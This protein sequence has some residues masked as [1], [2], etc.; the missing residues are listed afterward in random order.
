M[1]SLKIRVFFIPFIVGVYFLSGE[2]IYWTL[3]PVIF[4]TAFSIY[5][6][7]YKA[8]NSQRGEEIQTV[9]ELIITL[10]GVIGIIAYFSATAAIFWM[11]ILVAAYIFDYVRQNTNKPG[12]Y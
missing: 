9:G 3:V 4:I 5:N 11:L 8:A 10:F 7:Y 6:K 1:G 12:V 2:S